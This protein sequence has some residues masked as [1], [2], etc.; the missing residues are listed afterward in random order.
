[1]DFSFEF[2]SRYFKGIKHKLMTGDP[3]VYQCT[4]AIRPN[5]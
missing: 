2:Y 5:K 4:N 3:R 1:M